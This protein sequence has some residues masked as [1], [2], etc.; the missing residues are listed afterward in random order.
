MMIRK[1]KN[2][3]GVYASR[4]YKKGEVICV[5]T[6]KKKSLGA[7]YHQEYHKYPLRNAIDDPLQIGN[8]L[9]LDLD[10]PFLYINHSCEPS[11][12]IRGMSTL[13]ALRNIKKGKEITFDYSTS[14]DESFR[15]KC[16]SRKCRK[17]V[18]DFFAL[19]RKIQRSYYNRGALPDFIMKKFKK[20]S[21]D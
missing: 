15:C 4:S 2:G 8:N 21:K 16:G 19:P 7:L 1:N 5:M 20:L 6:G 17:T 13:F 18:V 14:I 12:G 3:L 11:A 10:R 9:Y